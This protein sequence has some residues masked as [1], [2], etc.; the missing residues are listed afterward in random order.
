MATIER[1]RPADI[2]A[3]RRTEAMALRIAGH[4]QQ[5]VAEKLGVTQQRVSAI[6]HEWLAAREPSSEVTEARR[7]VQL[8][9]I[10]DVK[11]RLFALLEAEVDTPARLG[12]V[13]RIVKCWDREARLV[14][15]DLQQ[16]I[17]VTVITREAVAELLWDAAPVIDVAEAVEEIPDA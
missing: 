7:Q 12:V 9:G 6:E 14:G 13:D 4:S 5:A 11:T 1:K 2:A 15:L 8:A 3:V 17:S 10:D 16:G